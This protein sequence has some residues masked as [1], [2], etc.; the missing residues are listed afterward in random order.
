M[1][2]A[3]DGVH[4]R[5]HMKISQLH[6]LAHFEGKVYEVGMQVVLNVV[7]NLHVL[8]SAFT[9]C[10]IVSACSQPIPHISAI[11]HLGA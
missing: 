9:A 5:V 1:A 4:V 7:G 11:S 2:E 8:V 3:A 10:S 6:R